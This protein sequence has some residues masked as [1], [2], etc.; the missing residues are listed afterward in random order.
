[1]ELP[2]ALLN[3]LARDFGFTKGVRGTVPVS[4]EDGDYIS[5]AASFIAGT[6]VGGVGHRPCRRG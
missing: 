4:L 5:L 1:M 3:A 2:G 6:L